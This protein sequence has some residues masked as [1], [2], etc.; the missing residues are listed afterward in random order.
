MNDT[1]IIVRKELKEIW[2][3]RGSLRSRLLSFLPILLVFGIYLPLQQR[4]AWTEV[5]AVSGIWFMMLPLFLAGGTAA[6]SFAG[7]RERHTLETLLATRL[8]DRDIFVGKVLAT[9]LYCVGITWS[10]ALLGW[11]AL[12]VT[13]GASPSFMYSAPVLALITLGSTLVSLLMTAVGVLVSLRAAS[14]RSA[15][16]VSSMV[17]LVLFIGLP[18]LLQALPSSVREAVGV[19]LAGANWGVLGSVAALV[20]LLIDV[21]LLMVGVARFQRARLVLE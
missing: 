5:P 19:A 8:S 14:V 13:K 4:E 20:V 3:A 6:D 18:V 2:R 15:A 9:V 1:W 11:T 7:E 10:C 17:T 16:Q 21:A 12:N